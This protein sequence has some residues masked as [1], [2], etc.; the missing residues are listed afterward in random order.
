MKDCIYDEQLFV[1]NM[2]PIRGSVLS[3]EKR[4]RYVTKFS[5]SS[6]LVA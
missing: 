2:T 3:L 6:P 5:N 4:K 1:H